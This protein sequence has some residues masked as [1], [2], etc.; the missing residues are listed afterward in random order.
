MWAGSSRLCSHY[1]AWQLLRLAP[2]QKPY[3][4]GLM[5][6]QNSDSSLLAEVSH[7]EAKMRER[8]ETLS[9][10][11]L[12]PRR[13][14]PLLAGNSDSGVVSETPERSYQVSWAHARFPET[15]AFKYFSHQKRIAINTYHPWRDEEMRDSDD[16]LGFQDLSL[17][18]RN[19][20]CAV[21]YGSI[22][23]GDCTL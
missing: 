15:N 6:T 11:S 8:R 5:F 4:I 12:L 14:R 23:S 2:I 10:L 21:S 20:T 13:E 7:D 22:I 3:Q 16:S 1:T 9:F 18:W 19:G 17:L